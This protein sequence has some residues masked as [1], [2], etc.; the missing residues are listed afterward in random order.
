M[1]IPPPTCPHQN[2][3]WALNG[4]LLTHQINHKEATL[5]EITPAIKAVPDDAV[6]L[7]NA[8]AK[9]EKELFV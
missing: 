6:H 7:I 9:K 3:F 5:K 1:K 2:I 8:V 4:P